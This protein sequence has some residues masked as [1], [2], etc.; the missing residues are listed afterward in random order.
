MT[1][2]DNCLGGRGEIITHKRSEAEVRYAFIR[3][4]PV[5]PLRSTTDWAFTSQEWPTSIFSQ[6]H[7]YII[8]KKG[9]ENKENDPDRVV[10]SRVKITQG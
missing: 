5:T 6:H 9:F 1:F 7:Q 2:A 4:R 10:Q 3:Q 8:Q